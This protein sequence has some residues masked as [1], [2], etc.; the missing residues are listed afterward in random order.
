MSRPPFIHPLHPQIVFA[1]AI[2]AV[3]AL[4]LDGVPADEFTGTAEGYGPSLAASDPSYTYCVLNDVST[5]PPG[6]VCE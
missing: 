4:Q 6:R 3:T 2:A 1:I 5:Q